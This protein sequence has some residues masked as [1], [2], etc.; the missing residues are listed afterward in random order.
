M[1]C[2]YCQ[3][4]NSSNSKFCYNCGKPFDFSKRI[5]ILI[6]DVLLYILSFFILLFC[7]IS[8]TI[9]N[10]TISGIL[11]ILCILIICP[12][13]YKLII[14]YIKFFN[15]CVIRVMF[16]IITFFAA[17][18]ISFTSPDPENHSESDQTIKLYEDVQETSKQEQAKIEELKRI[19]YE[20]AKAEE[21]KRIAEEQAKAEEAKRIAEEQA[22]EEEENKIVQ[23]Q[24]KYSYD[25]EDS[26]TNI[27]KEFYNNE[28]RAN[29]NYFGK[30]VKI[31]AKIAKISVDSSVLFNT[32]VTVILEESGAYYDILCN[33]KEGDSTGITK[34]NKGD[35]IT[36]IGKMDEFLINSIYMKK[37]IIVNN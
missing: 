7:L 10:A 4:E 28:A 19:A 6:K 25:I 37:C 26:L 9:L 33:F 18:F 30:K 12:I 22:R 24:S 1:K 27:S 34:Y 15:I 8:F 11:F 20:Q 5:S 16:A 3:A 32:G 13:S 29:K 35:Q 21:T 14:K 31:T 36:I 2:T 17:L 23:N